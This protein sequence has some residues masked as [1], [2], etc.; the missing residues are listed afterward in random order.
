MPTSMKPIRS[1]GVDAALAAAAREAHRLEAVSYYNSLLEREDLAE[2]AQ[3]L[4]SHMHSRG[5]VFGERL[6]CPFLRPHFC[7]REQLDLLNSAVRGVV[8]ACNV[9]APRIQAQPELQDALGLSEDERRLCAVDP[10]YPEFSVT[11]RLD[12]FMLGG[13]VRF[14]EYNAESPAGIGYNDVMQDVF[15]STSVMK[16]FIREFPC[17]P[18]Y[19]SET[20]LNSLLDCYK[21]WG[22]TDKP[23]IGI[24]DYEGL[25]T[26]HEFEIF[27]RFFNSRGY[28]CVVADPRKLDY[29]GER[30]AFEGQTINLVYRRLLTTEF[31]ERYDVAKPVWEAYR[32]RKI[33]MVNNFR[34]KYLHKKA[35]FALITDPVYQ[36]GMTPEQLFAVYTHV[37][38]TRRVADV[39][40][41]DVEG[42]NI[43]LLDWVR[44]N[45]RQLVMKPNDE[46]GG[47]GIFVGWEMNDDD[48]DKAIQTS[49]ES[50][51]LVQNKVEV[52][53]EVYP[54]W[55]GK[56][57]HWAEYSVD[58]DPFI[59][60]GE[61]EGLLTRLSATA[62][63][64]VTAGG[65][66]VPTF[67]LD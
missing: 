66:V 57:V 13:K 35:I 7:G 65:G 2:F 29:N 17:K 24:V 4:Q 54:T 43:E 60:K 16:E 23:C 58:L 47:K 25:P 42:R 37:P 59:F 34:A 8:G 61:V 12:S 22:G 36:D 11:S 41:T 55:D 32:D 63:C 51:Y 50:F 39:R 56:T 20:L 9:L 45:R 26:R 1:D 5:A 31:L 6:M 38:W 30:L 21:T 48:W 33:C 67:V 64:N 40:T 62:L 3:E 27:R 14:V 46:Y 52:S 10:G 44:K 53:R 49:L 15:L 28:Q 18:L 19:T